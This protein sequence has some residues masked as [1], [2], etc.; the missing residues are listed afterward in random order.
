MRIVIASKHTFPFM[1]CLRGW[2][3]EHEACRT[4]LYGILIS[5]S[6][7]NPGSFRELIK[8]QEIGVLDSARTDGAIILAKCSILI[9]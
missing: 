4:P 1:L 8:F 7:I 6:Y 3:R 9:L 5:Y 2:L